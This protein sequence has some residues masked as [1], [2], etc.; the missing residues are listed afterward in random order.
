MKKVRLIWTFY[1][2]F[3]LPAFVITGLL[4]WIVYRQGWQTFNIIFW[5]KLI[6]SVIIVWFVNG[7]KRSEYYYYQN[8]GVSKNQIWAY[9]MGIDWL[10][11]SIVFYFLTQ[12]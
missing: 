2:N 11:F 12:K 6:T 7:F 9:A 8:F 5:A 10:I 1:K 4:A 3:A